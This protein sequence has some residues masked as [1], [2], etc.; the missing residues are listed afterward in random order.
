[1]RS[2]TLALPDR[3]YW[4]EAGRLLA[5]AYPGDAH[6]DLAERK[7]RALLRV[8]V[9]T[10]VNLMEEDETNWAGLRFAPYAPHVERWAREVAWTRG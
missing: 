7:I 8:G 5:G 9:R 1:M 6:P 10:F 2:T 3:T 4:A